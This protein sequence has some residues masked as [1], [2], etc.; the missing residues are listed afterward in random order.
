M[1]NNTEKGIAP[2]IA[3][4]HSEE[5]IELLRRLSEDSAARTK[6]EKAQTLSAR[7]RTAGVVVL[8]LAVAVMTL[9]IVPRVNSAMDEVDTCLVQLNSI[10][11]TLDEI[12]FVGLAQS[13]E[14]LA[15]NGNESLA[16]AMDDLEGALQG[17]DAAI[18]TI[19]ALDIESL[20]KSIDDFG[21]VVEPLAKFFGKK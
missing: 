5:T 18:S 12:D 15:V 21:A 11:S 1:D 9:I 7:I 6:Y 8:A 20:N 16:T 19:S 13:V 14:T 2:E 3:N 17:V 4:S 10:T